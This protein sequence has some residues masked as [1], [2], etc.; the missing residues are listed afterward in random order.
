MPFVSWQ[1]IPLEGPELGGESRPEMK[2]C[3]D[4]IGCAHL[5]LLPLSF[6]PFVFD[7]AKAPL[8]QRLRQSHCAN[9]GCSKPSKSK[10]AILKEFQVDPFRIITESTPLKVSKIRPKRVY[11]SRA[12]MR[13]AQRMAIGVTRVGNIRKLSEVTCS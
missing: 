7:G 4:R 8:Y 13:A 10:Y 9:I 1:T 6:L 3:T 11:S 12:R 5:G 2:R